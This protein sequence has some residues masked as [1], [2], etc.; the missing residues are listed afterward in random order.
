M[1][2]LAYRVYQDR[3]LG[4]WLGKSIGGALGAEVENHKH[5]GTLRRDELWPRELPPNDDLD[6]Q[7]V[8]LELMQ[9][10]GMYFTQRDLVAY[11]QE[12]CWYNFC[13]YGF[14]LYNVQ[15]GIAPPWSGSWNNE[16]FRESEG[17]PIRSD[18]WGLVAPGNPAL[19]AELARQDGQLDHAGLAVEA[20]QFYAAMTARAVPGATREELLTAGFSVLPA[21]S[22][23]PEVV[24]HVRDISTTVPGLEAA[25]RAVLRRYGDRDSTKAVTNLALMMLA[26]ERAGDDF[27]EAMRLC[28]N[29]GWDTDCTAATLGG[30]LGAWRGTAVIPRDWRGRL[31]ESINCALRI[32]HR[33]ARL[34]EL[35]EETARLGVEMSRSRN[36]E[37]V[38]SGA[39]DVVVRPQPEPEPELSIHYDT[40][41]V[42]YAGRATTVSLQCR[43]PWPHPLRGRLTLQPAPETR[44]SPEELELTLPPGVTTLPLTIQLRPGARLLPDRNLFRA[45][46]TLPG[47]EDT[48]LVFG[49]GGARQWLLYGPYWDMWDRSRYAECPYRGPGRNTMPCK[50]GCPADGCN[51]YVELNRPYLDEAALVEGRALTE[52]PWHLESGR[53]LLAGADFGGWFGPAVY[54]LVRTIC[55]RPGEKLRI[56]FGRA[57]QLR[58]WLDGRLLV[59]SPEIHTWSLMD[60]DTVPVTLN[61]KPQ[62]LVVKLAGFGDR[63][64]LSVNFLRDESGVGRPGI[65]YLADDLVEVIPEQGAY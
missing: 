40:E 2:T 61:G 47:R 31:G 53:D 18:I 11:W 27:S 46:L 38:F 52:S 41:P 15:R 28:V 5:Y 4:A 55:G 65:S 26:W 60:R 12:R 45:V 48:E 19:A 6:I 20:E 21:G 7:L 42:L 9:E 43:N 49:L 56:N 62:R 64:E 22:R 36:P 16:F 23:I 25:W 17:C 59:D 37:V 54:Y 51:H 57:G 13:E 10:R 30:L 29:F 58:A 8:W 1:K 3:V 34:D 24:H 33:Y 35:A 50:A 44:I 63:P 39:P 32:D 14:F